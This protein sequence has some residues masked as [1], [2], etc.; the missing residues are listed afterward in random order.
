MRWTRRQRRQRPGRQWSFIYGKPKYEGEKDRS[1]PGEVVGE[2]VSN[3]AAMMLLDDAFEFLSDSESTCID[4]V[5]CATAESLTPQLPD[6]E[7]RFAFD[8]T[9][10]RLEH[11]EDGELEDGG[12]VDRGPGDKRI[13]CGIG[14]W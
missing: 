13:G 5:S 9:I 8:N 3:E 4:V 6:L 1:G 2:A 11:S 12:L 10:A 14:R 7:D